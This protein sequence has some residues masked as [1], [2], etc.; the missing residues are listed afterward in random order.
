MTTTDRTLRT[1]QISTPSVSPTRRSERGIRHQ[2]VSV[3][4]LSTALAI[5][6]T[7]AACSRDEA[8]A[9][10]AHDHAAM[11]RGA[12]APAAEISGGAGET[13][14]SDHAAN[15]DEEDISHWTCSMHPSVHEQKPGKCPICGMTLIPVKKTAGTSGEFPL[16]DAHAAAAGIR[17][18]VAERGQLRM[19][20]RA[21]GRVVP[22]ES[23]LT[24]VALAVGGFVRALNVPAVGERVTAGE[25]LFSLYGPELVAAQAELIRSARSGGVLADTA[26]AR[27]RRLGIAASDVDDIARRADPLEAVPVRAPFS[28]FVIEKNIVEGGAVAPNE[29]LVRIAASQ[30]MWIEAELFAPE[31]AS[32]TAGASGTVRLD[33]GGPLLDATVSFVSPMMSAQT[34]TGR[35][36][37]AIDNDA[38][39]LRPE[40]WAVVEITH[41]RPEHLLVPVDA[42]V[43]SGER[44]IVFVAREGGRISPREIQTGASDRERIE[45]LSGIEAGERV[46]ASGTFL[47]ASESRLRSAFLNR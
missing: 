21:P 20:I 24:D 41:V 37:L 43:H 45:V 15:S 4:L 44:R 47:V 16:D 28:G 23:E 19:S 42:V 9:P 35:V 5:L 6:L 33:D 26:R 39:R 31:L 40:G 12:T 14:H 13:L 30:R 2:A 7:G 1:V 29:R 32:V 46:V 36:R 25:R 17:F 38:G 3:A 34:R 22:A 10:P 8:T 11:S 27:M 18:G